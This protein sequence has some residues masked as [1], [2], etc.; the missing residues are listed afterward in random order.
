MAH[1][2][3]DISQKRAL[4]GTVRLES[5]LARIYVDDSRREDF[6]AGP[7]EFALRHELN[8]EEAAAL[9]SID[10]TV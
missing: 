2:V 9:F 6:L 8:S 1:S 7:A 10:R 5:L 4:G 3:R